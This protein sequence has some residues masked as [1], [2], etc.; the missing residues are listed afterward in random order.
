MN[1]SFKVDFRRNYTTKKNF[2]NLKKTRKHDEYYN[3]CNIP[4]LLL[5]KLLSFPSKYPY[6][7]QNDILSTL[8]L[9][10]LLPSSL[11]P[12]LS[13]PKKRENAQCVY[14]S[15][16]RGLKIAIIARAF[17][18]KLREWSKILNKSLTIRISWIKLPCSLANESLLFARG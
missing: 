4:Q 5:Q 8:S 7:Y 1:I 16:Y 15:I 14:T 3:R 13:F 9:S 18:N 12:S 2:A 17:R 11:P 6:C 10:L